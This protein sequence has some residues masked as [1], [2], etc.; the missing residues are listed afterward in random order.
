MSIQDKIRAAQ[1]TLD[2][3][4]THV[5]AHCLFPTPSDVADRLA[6]Y[7][8]LFECC[9]VLEPSN[10]TGRLMQAVERKEPTA[11]VAT[12]EQ[13][14]AL[15]KY[16]SPGGHFVRDFLTAEHFEFDRVVMNPPFNGGSDI[17]HVQHAMQFVKPGGILVAIVANGPRQQKA[18]SSFE[19]LEELPAGTFTGTQ[20]RAAVVRYRSL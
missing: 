11:L 14:P 5:T 19:W 4:V 20:A 2:A 1:S 10:G 18:F 8:E 9:M 16:G 13:E 12:I 17:L 15:A 7:A 3:G 6:S